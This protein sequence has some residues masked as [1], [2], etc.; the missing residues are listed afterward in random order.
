MARV[1]ATGEI[2]LQSLFYQSRIT[3][4]VLTAINAIFGRGKRPKSKN[5]TEIDVAP[6]EIAMIFGP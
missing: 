2:S 5:A 3:K 4:F 1:S 6:H